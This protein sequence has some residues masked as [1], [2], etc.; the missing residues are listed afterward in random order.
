LAQ[1]HNYT[2]MKFHQQHKSTAAGPK[3]T[4]KYSKCIQTTT[5]CL[6]CVALQTIRSNQ[7]IITNKQKFSIKSSSSSSSLLSLLPPPVSHQGYKI[8][9]LPDQKAFSLIYDQVW[10]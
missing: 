7:Y 10:F 5:Y 9:K 3:N 8:K 6:E 4:Y 1:I 2:G